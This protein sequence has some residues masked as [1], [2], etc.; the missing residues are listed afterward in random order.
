MTDDK[1]K[2]GSTT[3][4]VTDTVALDES[5]E[6]RLIV[7]TVAG[8]SRVSAIQTVNAVGVTVTNSASLVSTVVS[9]TSTTGVIRITWNANAGSTYELERQELTFGPNS[10]R[11]P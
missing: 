7:R 11:T 10:A 1:V 9:T 3:W 8:V 6:Y 2:T 5:Y 4:Q